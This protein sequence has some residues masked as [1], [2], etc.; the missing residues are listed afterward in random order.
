METGDDPKEFIAELQERRKFLLLLASEYEE[1]LRYDDLRDVER[2]R[3]SEELQA[4]KMQIGSIDS[5][6]TELID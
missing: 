6:L 1:R 5:K 2:E 3:A 4:L